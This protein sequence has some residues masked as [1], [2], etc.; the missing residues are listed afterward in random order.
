MAFTISAAM[1]MKVRKLFATLGVPGVIASGNKRAFKSHIKYSCRLNVLYFVYTTPY[2][3]GSAGT[4]EIFVGVTKL[5]QGAH[6]MISRF[7]T[8]YLSEKLQRLTEN[9]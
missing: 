7:C 5:R 8:A 6:C 4:S 3:P 9:W 1:I 2:Y